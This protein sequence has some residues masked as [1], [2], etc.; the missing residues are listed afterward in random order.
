MSPV[1]PENFSFA[2]RRLRSEGKFAYRVQSM[3]THVTK[4]IETFSTTVTRSDS[5]KHYEMQ[6]AISRSV[7]RNHPSTVASNTTVKTTKVSPE[8]SNTNM[9]DTIDLDMFS[10]V[11]Q[12]PFTQACKVLSNSKVVAQVNHI[13]KVNST[14][15][16]TTQHSTLNPTY[17]SQDLSIEF[18]QSMSE[19]DFNQASLS[20]VSSVNSISQLERDAKYA[21]NQEDIRVEHVKYAL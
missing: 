18:E 11:S 20:T 6:S 8:A 10:Q 2:M 16:T 9:G 19:D 5:T 7:M 14:T 3:N 12:I 17:L 13:T 4:N 1:S 15:N 21:L